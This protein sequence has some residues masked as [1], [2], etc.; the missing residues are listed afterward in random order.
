MSYISYAKL[1]SYLDSKGIT[2][3]YL[4]K[5]G[6]ITDFAYRNIIK[7]RD[8]NTGQLAN[9]CRYLDIPIEQAVEIIRD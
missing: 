2:L 4:K 3:N 5:N 7:G 6:I 8:V 1:I 9:I